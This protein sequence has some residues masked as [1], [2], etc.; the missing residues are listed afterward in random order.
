MN[1][2][3][4]LFEKIKRIRALAQVGLIYSTNE[5]DTDRYN[6]LLD[7]SNSMTSLITNVKPSVIAESFTIEKEYIT[8]KVDVRGVIFNEQD[9]ILLVKE[10]ADNKW[11]LPGGW[12]E[13]GYSPTEGVVKEVQ[14]ETGLNVRPIR[15]LAVLD[16]RCHPYPPALHYV[17]KIF[18]QCEVKDGNLSTTFDILDVGYFKQNDLPTLSEERVIKKHINLMFEY[19]KNPS[20]KARID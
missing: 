2:E 4:E 5:Y 11:S 17:Y 19:K 16:K 20:K 8:P 15:L 10:K 7:I 13:V 9:E 6:E 3:I 1:K 14:E 18:I 12:A